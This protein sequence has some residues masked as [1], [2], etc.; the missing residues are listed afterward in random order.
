MDLPAK[1][2][3]AVKVAH[4]ISSL[5]VILFWGVGVPVVHIW[6]AYIVAKH[7]DSLF[8]GILAVALPVIAPI[9]AIILTVG[10]GSW[11]YLAVVAVGVIAVLIA[12]GICDCLDY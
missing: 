10:S 8:L 3:P 6:A 2:S 1:W 11:L 7:H 12:G 9:W 4:G 5:L